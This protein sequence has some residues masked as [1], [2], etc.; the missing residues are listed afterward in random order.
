MSAAS[1]LAALHAGRIFQSTISDDAYI[2]FRYARNLGRGDG[3]AWNPGQAPVEG[4]TSLLQVVLLAGA[5][6][7]GADMEWASQALGL[8]SFVLSIPAAAWLAREVTGGDTRAGVLAAFALALSPP[9]AAW[10][11]GGLETPAFTFLLTAAMACWLSESRRTRRRAGSSVLFFLATLSRPEGF[12]IWALTL[13]FDALRA[14]GDHGRRSVKRAM[15]E[16]S[17]YLAL[18]SGYMAWKLWYFGD[19]LPNTFHAKAGGGL[20][21]LQTGVVYVAGFLLALGPLALMLC[22]VPPLLRGW[23]R[24]IP[25]AYV[26]CC[27]TAYL[28]EV[29]VIG[30]DY[31]YFWRYAVPVL[32]M[33]CGL[34]ASGFL[35]AWDACCRLPLSRR[36]MAA[37]VTL[38]LAAYPWSRASL[39][40]VRDEPA[41]LARPWRLVDRSQIEAGDFVLMGRMLD[42]VVPPG[43]TLA[44]LAVGAIGYYCDRPILDLLG[45]NDRTIARL[46]L[47]KPGLRK[48][49]P[50]H[51]RGSAA[52]LLRRKPDFVLLSLRPSD[53]PGSG[54]P[55]RILSTYPFVADLMGS[56]EFRRAYDMESHALPDGR[57]LNV[58]RLVGAR[59][60]AAAGNLSP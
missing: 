5:N 26:A 46:P 14:A 3:L 40:E 35:E 47:A 51:M 22:V 24:M 45:L 7:V 20:W 50:G 52:E 18:L 60:G 43:R 11:R 53:S 39:H 9:A 2:L 41:R 10:A 31:Q 1:L 8:L 27:A 15:M 13:T 55:E 19:I 54:P 29:A 23:R 25:G 4:F 49:E 33:I 21:A 38:T 34:C 12:G 28:A 59:E 32:P 56:E 16:W 44:A 48:W 36:R 17:P 58:F 30:G 37:V 42:Q 57:W 6:T